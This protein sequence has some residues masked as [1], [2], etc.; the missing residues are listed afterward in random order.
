[1][2]ITGGQVVRYT[3]DFG[4]ELAAAEFFGCYNFA[5]CSFDEGGPGQENGSGILD[6][7]GFVRHGRDVGATKRESLIICIILAKMGLRTLLYKAP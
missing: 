4:V 3:G 6:D 7:D 5:G 1:M 2:C